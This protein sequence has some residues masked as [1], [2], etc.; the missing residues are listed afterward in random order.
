MLSQ[1]PI[2]KAIRIITASL[3]SSDDKID[4][5]C[6]AGHIP[7]QRRTSADDPDYITLHV[8][9]QYELVARPSQQTINT[10]SLEKFRR[11]LSEHGLDF[12]EVMTAL[13]LATVA[14]R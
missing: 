5:Y 3:R 7:G 12:N 9:Y 11:D 8:T 6:G 2:E 14:C 4:V 10:E 1:N 13:T